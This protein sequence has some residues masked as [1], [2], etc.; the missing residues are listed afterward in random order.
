MELQVLTEILVPTE[1][2]V[3][4]EILVPTEQLVPMEQR[5]LTEILVQMANL[6]LLH[7]KKIERFLNIFVRANQV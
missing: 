3:P 7:L 6:D 5:V 2:L 1:Q 4:M